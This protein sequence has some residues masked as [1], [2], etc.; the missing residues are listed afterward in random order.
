MSRDTSAS[1]VSGNALFHDKISIKTKLAVF[2]LYQAAF[3]ELVEYIL[4]SIEY[5]QFI[6]ITLLLTRH[7]YNLREPESSFFMETVF[8]FAKLLNFGYFFENSI[9]MDL[10]LTIFIIMILWT[11]MCSVLFIYS[12]IS[13][14]MESTRSTVLF[15]I[16]SW[17]AK[18]HT[19]LILFEA[20]SFA[21]VTTIVIRN[22]NLIITPA[23]REIYISLHNFLLSLGYTSALYVVTHS[24]SILPSKNL[25][26]S[27]SCIPQVL[28]TT[29]KFSLTVFYL[30]L[31]PN[32]LTSLLIMS[33]INLCF[34]LSI[35]YFYFTRLPDYNPKGIRHRVLLIAVATLLSI[36]FFIRAIVLAVTVNNFGIESTFFIWIILAPLAVKV[37]RTYVRRAYS[38]A[39]KLPPQETSPSSFIHKLVAINDIMKTRKTPGFG[40]KVIDE[41]YLHYKS[42]EKNY[43]TILGV[44]DQQVPEEG[45]TKTFVDRMIILYLEDLSTKFPKDSFLKLYIAYFYSKK[46]K[47][48]GRALRVI[49]QLELSPSPYRNVVSTLILKNEIQSIMKKQHT[50]SSSSINLLDYVRSMIAVSKLKEKIIKQAELQTKLY[51][52]YVHSS[53]SLSKLLDWSL[54]ISQ[55]REDIQEETTVISKIAPESYLKPYMI[56]MPYHLIMNHSN[57]AYLDMGKALETKYRKHQR[58]FKKDSLDEANMYHPDNLFL[59]VSGRKETAGKIFYCSKS[60]ERTLS[61]NPRLLNGKHI[62]CLTSPNWKSSFVDKINEFLYSGDQGLLRNTSRHFVMSRSG[63]IVQ[64]DSCFDI[65][66][67]MQ[68][69]FCINILMRPVPIAMDYIIF[70]EDGKIESFTREIG[71][72]LGLLRLMRS[73]NKRDINIKQISPELERVNSIF[74][75]VGSLNLNDDSESKPSNNHKTREALR[76]YREYST[77]GKMILFTVI[78]SEEASDEEDNNKSLV[79]NCRIKSPWRG[80]SQ[81]KLCILSSISHKQNNIMKK[82][83]LLIRDKNLVDDSLNND[84]D[85]KTKLDLISSGDFDTENEIEEEPEPT[86][87]NISLG[88]VPSPLI[89]LE[90]A[91]QRYNANRILNGDPLYDSAPSS[92]RN[93]LSFKRSFIAGRQSTSPLGL[94]RINYLK[95]NSQ[96]KAAIILEA[97]GSIDSQKSQYKGNNSSNSLYQKTMTNKTY[98]RYF[99]VCFVYFCLVMAILAVVEFYTK[100]ALATSIVTIYESKKALETS[101]TRSLLLLQTAYLIHLAINLSTV[102]A[103]VLSPSSSNLN[104][105]KEILRNL[106]DISNIN[107]M[108]IITTESL[109]TSERRNMFNAN[110]EICTQSSNYTDPNCILLNIFQAIDQTLGSFYKI[111][112]TYE[113]DPMRKSNLVRSAM[114]NSLNDVAVRSEDKSLI[115]L[116]SVNNMNKSSKRVI[117]NAL[118]NAAGSLIVVCLTFICIIIVQYRLKKS[119]MAAFTRLDHSSVDMISQRVVKFKESL[120]KESYL[121]NG[122]DQQTYQEF[123]SEWLKMRDKSVSKSHV[124]TK[125]PDS[126]GLFRRHFL[127]LLRL[128]II[129]FS[130][131]GLSAINY[132]LALKNVES[133][134]NSLDQIY[135]SYSTNRK[136]QLSFTTLYDLVAYNDT[137]MV[138]NHKASD[139][140]TYNLEQFQNIRDT[141]TSR[142]WNRESI[143]YTSIIQS[144]LF[145]NPCS[146]ILKLSAECVQ[147]QGQ[148]TAKNLMSLLSSIESEERDI[149]SSYMQS[150]KSEEDCQGLV[151]KTDQFIASYTPILKLLQKTINDALEQSFEESISKSKHMNKVIGIVLYVAIILNTVLAW[152]FVFKPVRE[153]TNNFKKVLQVFPPELVLS[154]FLLKKYLQGISAQTLHL[155]NH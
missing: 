115:F 128:I 63:Y 102:N 142:F 101:E 20:M 19:Q 62:S 22:Q 121:R 86:V 152:K 148:S 146:D 113:D 43:E 51:K 15:S 2:S 136:I 53:P 100:S 107:Q 70:Y 8:W 132:L 94:K 82:E 24:H 69:G 84:S 32:S 28:L 155:D 99:N 58:S 31:G 7:L 93:L 72:R 77:T 138:H 103:T 41:M 80:D 30:F 81:L 14:F 153:S 36:V 68:L 149:Y 64:M 119:N 38:R 46:L 147:S 90:N 42:L 129:M 37:S 139:Q 106:D 123:S 45:L 108:L 141:V 29:Q 33:T 3:P 98:P 76:I 73:D 1:L 52:E 118:G 133:I 61:W 87:K 40:N 27:T 145:G 26:A 131:L 126:S 6:S 78:D 50:L 16:W 67:F 65:H 4:L 110:V 74:N 125:E 66:P 151:I 21:V 144:L 85:A 75:L 18:F 47:N 57:I 109:D 35:S 9:N 56:L 13:G 92:R 89:H 154:N 122:I 54:K 39:V 95:K 111:M 127:F 130:L 150:N 17:I 96:K 137:I 140:L 5:A 79:Y 25:L 135:M 44:K 55:Y 116:N 88:L 104:T 124:H 60:S 71:E 117:I 34:S 48:Y 11:V 12:F 23:A 91:E 114:N 143:T 49:G 83:N 10:F 59:I 112:N 105:S 97:E 120:E 134:Y